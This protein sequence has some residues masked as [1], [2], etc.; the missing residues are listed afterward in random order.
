M[1]RQAERAC[2]RP[3]R[4]RKPQFKDR[5]C[6]RFV[7][8][9]QRDRLR[10]EIQTAGEDFTPQVGQGQRGDQR[11]PETAETH[12]G[13]LITQRGRGESRRRRSANAKLLAPQRKDCRENIQRLGVGWRRGS[14]LGLDGRDQAPAH[15]LAEVQVHVPVPL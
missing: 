7:N 14:Y 13:R 15:L 12:V 4:R 6:N 2:S 10:R 3:W 8:R 9:T 11:L 1:N 5:F